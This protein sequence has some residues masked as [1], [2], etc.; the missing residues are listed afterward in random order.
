MILKSRHD[1][2][3]MIVVGDRNFFL[4]SQNKSH[5]LQGVSVCRGKE[6][7][8]KKQ[9]QKSISLTKHPYLS[10]GIRQWMWDTDINKNTP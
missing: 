10:D 7:V 5:I 2:Q 1:D 4:T 9:R 6:L 8:V 3:M